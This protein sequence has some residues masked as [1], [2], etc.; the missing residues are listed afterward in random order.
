MS[1]QHILLKVVFVQ[2]NIIANLRGELESHVRGES[3]MHAILTGHKQL[4][5][6]SR[7]DQEVLIIDVKCSK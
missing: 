2:D 7:G 6:K 3:E 5:E 4:V 1:I